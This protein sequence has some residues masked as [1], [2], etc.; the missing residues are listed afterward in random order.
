MTI[1]SAPIPEEEYEQFGGDAYVSEALIEKY[2][3]PAGLSRFRKWAKEM[4]QT[5][6]GGKSVYFPSDYERWVELGLPDHR[7]NTD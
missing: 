3:T 2:H 4:T 5:L 7:S 6:I 1:P